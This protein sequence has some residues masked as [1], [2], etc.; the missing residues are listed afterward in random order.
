MVM[1]RS[2]PRPKKDKIKKSSRSKIKSDLFWKK[3]GI[4]A[5]KIAKIISSFQIDKNQGAG[6]RGLKNRLLMK[7]IKKA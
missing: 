2:I 4:A 3:V 7:V 1:M 5:K 6:K